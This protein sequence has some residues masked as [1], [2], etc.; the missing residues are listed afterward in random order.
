MKITT[1]LTVGFSTLFALVVLLAAVTLF[2]LTKIDE[3]FK[4]VMENRYRK[5]VVAN[6]IKAVNSEE[7]QSM[8]NLFIMS[9]P[10]DVKAEFDALAAGTKTASADMEYLQQRTSNG[11]AQ[12]AFARLL[13]ARAA[14]SEPR[15]KVIELL[16]AAKFDEAKAAMIA[17]VR[18]RQ[19]DFMARID[20]LIKLQEVQMGEGAA[21]MGTSISDTKIILGALLALAFA[22]A[23]ALG[24]WIV[25]T[26]TR[27]I[28]DAVNIARGVAAGDL[29]MEF[30]ADGK[31]E[32]GLLLGALHDMK[33]R[34]AAIV[35]DVRRNAEG[36]ASAAAQIA[37][38]NNDLSSRTE[39]QASALEETAASMEQLSSTVKQ[40]ADNA[41]QA[42]QLA[43]GASSVAI[44]GGEVVSQVVDTMRDIN[45]SS[46]KIVDIISVIDGIA[47][48]TNI[49]ALNAAVEA[50]RAGEQG[51][52]FA[53]VASE[54][55]SL[56]Q[57]SAEAA[58]EIKVLISASV[59]RVE[60]GT[61]LVDRA[62]VT[63]QE[64]VASI[65]R[66]TDLMGEI[67]AAS[68]EQ[69][70]GVAQIGEAVTQMD[71]ATQQNAALVEESAAAAESLKL[72]AQQLV[73]TVAVFKLAHGSRVTA[74]PALATAAAQARNSVERRGPGRAQNLNQP[75]LDAGAKADV[76]VLT[77]EV[78]PRKTGAEDDWTSF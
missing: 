15:S 58:K 36:T 3:A 21:A 53:V 52:G 54:V 4:D 22:A 33:T 49:L 8:R 19:V 61:T 59:E 68:T 47:F 48:Q 55:R 31:N 35:G 40:N 16:R 41:R 26:T 63:M 56:A 1:R 60:Q 62:G 42:N 2:N 75:K 65:R 13:E 29:A 73:Q 39:Q 6:D 38:G 12:Q 77:S 71:Q 45:A 66:V 76:P 18:P 50:A 23:A 46:K 28:N 64:V 43:Q 17:E 9:D 32:T 30:R 14:Y 5:V 70:A 11:R 34:L 69:S 7:A 20:D 24:V 51:R 27:P 10:A 37:Q 57:R 25:R 67:S 74:A 44:Q 72:Q 78:S